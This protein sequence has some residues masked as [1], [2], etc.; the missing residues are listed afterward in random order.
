[1]VRSTH[2]VL[3]LLL[4]AA[5]APV[6]DGSDDSQVDPQVSDVTYV[7]A[8][9]DESLINLIAIEPRQEPS[10]QLAIQL[11]VP[12]GNYPIAGG[13][14]ISFTGPLALA[15]SSSAHDTSSSSAGDSPSG[16]ERVR[17]V[18]AA[19][20]SELTPIRAAYAHGPPFNGR[21]YYLRLTDSAGTLSLEVFTDAMSYVVAP[22]QLTALAQASQPLRLTITWGDFDQDLL[23]PSTGPFAGGFV[24][25]EIRTIRSWTAS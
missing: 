20:T 5:C 18:L 13:L 11:P 22:V 1:M 17:Q 25:Y 10:K 19:L 15:P 4:L 9:N 14:T 21:G 3:V 2:F 8:A 16:V 12:A 23:G 7:G 24:D 6:N